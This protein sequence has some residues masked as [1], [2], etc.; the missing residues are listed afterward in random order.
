MPSFDP[1]PYIGVDLGGTNM[2][3]AIVDSNDRV[4]R[5]LRRRTRAHLGH[6]AVL[7]R[8]GE[9]VEL[10]RDEAGL[11]RKQIAGLG[12]GIPGP[13]DMD[14]GVV[15]DAPN[16]GWEQLEIRDVLERITGLRT[17][18]GNDANVALYG[19]VKAG[20]A[21]G[22]EDALGIWTGTGVGGA[23]V[24]SG[25]L[26]HGHHFSAG[27]VGHTT[28]LPGAGLGHETLEEI[29][30]RS[31]MVRTLT[32]LIQG[33]HASAV[34]EMV[35]GDYSQTRSKILA[36][37]VLAGDSLAV[38]VV[39][40]AARFTGIAVANLVTTLS[41]PCVV[42][43]GGL[44]TELGAPWAEWVGESAAEHVWP[45]DL[46]ET[47]VMI[48]RLGDDSGTIGAAIAAREKCESSE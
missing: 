6:Q 39:R 34:T 37:A 11:T 9:I 2:S 20:A 3:A 8:I 41:L 1:L 30:S 43:G 42:L 31:A 25:R 48:A 32:A 21:V 17:I 35:D 23:L 28:V 12:V 46:P 13:V 14:R 27:E 38:R 44:P 36:R 16:L 26:Y 29:A 15:L 47:R 40:D 7:E 4:V 24:L 5:A 10:V 18:L 22:Y 33:G 45:R 19:E